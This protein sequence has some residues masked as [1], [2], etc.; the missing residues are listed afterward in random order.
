MAN[1]VDVV[2]KY[3]RPYKRIALIVFI[4]AIFLIV[5]YFW[6]KRR[7]EMEANKEF[8]DVANRKGGMVSGETSAPSSGGGGSSGSGSGSGSG[9]TSGSAS[10]GSADVYFFFADWCPHCK[11]SKP[12]WNTFKS[13]NHGKV[14][15]NYK[16]NCVEV[17][18]TD[19]KNAESGKLLDKYGVDS[20]PT[21]LM[22]KDGKTINFDSRVSNNA[23][24]KF[25][26]IM[27]E[28]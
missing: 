11:K 27:T 18:C 8:S 24:N 13:S 1:I 9:N 10:V 25:V 7:E 4:I 22:V 6:L 5:A 3:L 19:D 17:D 12:D 23:L 20:F 26:T 16:I 14:I 15:N 28:N 21:V 2:Y